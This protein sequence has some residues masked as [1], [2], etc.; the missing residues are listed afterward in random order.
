MLLNSFPR[1]E[2]FRSKLLFGDVVGVS[3]GDWTAAPPEDSSM[4]STSSLMIIASF[5]DSLKDHDQCCNE[6]FTISSEPEYF[7]SKISRIF[8]CDRKMANFGGIMFRQPIPPFSFAIYSVRNVVR[9][10][11]ST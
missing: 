4:F 2:F 5:L 9:L 1:K 3:P 8:W 11:T 10:D 7:I 6:I